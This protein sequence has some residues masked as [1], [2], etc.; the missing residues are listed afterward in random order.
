VSFVIPPTAEGLLAECDVD[1]FRSGGPGGQHQNVTDSGVRLRHRPS[2]AV[3]TS[4]SRRSQH[5]NKSDC[6]RRLRRKL[7]KLN[8]PPPPPRVETK[9]PAAVKR[10]RVEEKRRAGRRKRERAAPLAEDD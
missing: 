9:V 3:V 2:G 5:A 10:R 6:L 8:E 1:T 4:R 7:E